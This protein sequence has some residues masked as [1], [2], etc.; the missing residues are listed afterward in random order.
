MIDQTA[1]DA[2][3]QFGI[4]VLLDVNAMA[5]IDSSTLQRSAGP[6]FAVS[7]SGGT[8]TKCALIDNAIGVSVQGGSSLVEGD[9]TGDPLTVSISSDTIFSGNATRVGSGAIPL[10]PA[11]TTPK[12]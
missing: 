5:T 9:G 2:N 7:G 3:G 10:P 11:L 1:L 4:G 8:M 6:A 12:N